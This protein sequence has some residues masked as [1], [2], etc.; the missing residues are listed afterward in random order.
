MYL[1]FFNI[2]HYGFQV[3]RWNKRSKI[4]SEV[5]VV[6]VFIL[7]IY[8]VKF[9]WEAAKK[10]TLETAEQLQGECNRSACP[11]AIEGWDRRSYNGTSFLRVGKYAKYFLS[12]IPSEEKDS[13]RLVLRQDIDTDFIVEGGRGRDITATKYP[14]PYLEN[15]FDN[16]E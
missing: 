2:D 6:A 4:F 3:R 8:S 5:A 15:N 12:Y 16:N 14:L 13:Y 9:S 1:L 10:F 11:E 7:S